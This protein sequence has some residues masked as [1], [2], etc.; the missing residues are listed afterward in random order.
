MAF[1]V[2]LFRSAR[3]PIHGP[4]PWSRSHAPSSAPPRQPH[5]LQHTPRSPRTHARAECAPTLVSGPLQLVACH[6]QG[7]RAGHK[8]IPCPSEAWRV[9]P[10][11]TTRAPGSRPTSTARARDRASRLRKATACGRAAPPAWLATSSMPRP[12][13]SRR[14]G[15]CRRLRGRRRHTPL[16]GAVTAW[17]AYPCRPCRPFRPCHP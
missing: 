9:P 14:R 13:C 4:M 7:H 17:G 15:V 2:Q 11:P 1:W 10:L 3:A 5:T 6:T 8:I 12:S 16:R